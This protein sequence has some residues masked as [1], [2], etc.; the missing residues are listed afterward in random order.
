MPALTAIGYR[1]ETGHLSP[2]ERAALGRAAR[3]R[4]RRSA[5]EDVGDVSGGAIRSRCSRRRRPRACTSSCRSATAGCSSRRSPST[6]A[7]PPSWRPTSPR[8]RAPASTCRRA[9]T[10]TSPTSALFAAPDRRLVFDI[11]DFDETLPG[12]WEWDVKRL[13][14]SVEIAGRDRGVHPTPSAAADRLAA[15][16]DYREGDGGVRRDGEPRRLVRPPQRRR[17]RG[18][19][20]DRDDAREGAPCPHR[21]RRSARAATR[22]EPPGGLSKLTERVDGQLRFVS[23]PPLL[24]PLARARCPTSARERP[25]GLAQARP[26]AATAR[27]SPTDRR[28][29]ARRST[30]S[31]TWRARSSASAASGRAA[32]IVLLVGPRRPTTRCP[33]GEGGA[34]RRCWRRYLG[35]QRVSPTTASGSWPGSASCRP[36]AT[37]SWAGCASRRHR[38]A[39]QRDFY[40]RQLR[41][42][43][44][45]ADVE[46]MATARAG[47]LRRALRLVARPRA[48]PLRRPRRDRGLPRGRRAFD[49]AIARFAEA[50]ADQNERD[51]AALV[52][53]VAEGRV[54]ATSGV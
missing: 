54:R 10:R 29:A 44:A 37:S 4:T 32:W 26:D 34:G 9:A 2:S 15:V 28:R 52:A 19:L 39:W 8:R 46:A 14:A 53:A 3:G 38:T 48:C 17:A 47:G 13:A 5:H 24:V 12:P 7:R 16:R 31:S 25:A 40:V 23:G 18:A 43:K 45:S 51:H 33:A 22:D 50:Y 41:D 42:W 1:D 36:P 20:G 11:N 27:A 49:Q 6:A 30:G 21:Q 35:P